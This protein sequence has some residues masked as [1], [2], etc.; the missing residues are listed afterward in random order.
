MYSQFTTPYLLNLFVIVTAFTT[1][2]N[3]WQPNTIK[4]VQLASG[5][6]VSTPYPDANAKPTITTKLEN[7]SEFHKS[8]ASSTTTSTE[9]YPS[10]FGQDDS[11]GN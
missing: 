1:L 6:D 8:T 9:G 11:Y 10:L 5:A 4:F 3:Y 2:L 7:L